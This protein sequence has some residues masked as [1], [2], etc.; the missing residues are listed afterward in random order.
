MIAIER[1]NRYQ[2]FA[3]H[4]LLSLVFFLIVLLLITEFWYPGFLFQSSAGWDAVSLIVGIDLILGPLLT[5]IVFDTNKASLKKDL[6]VILA[7]QLTAL[8]AGSYTIWHT[9]PIAV[10]YHYPEFTTIYA[11]QSVAANIAHLVQQSDSRPAILFYD[12]PSGGFDNNYKKGEFYPYNP[13]SE[14]LVRMI[15]ATATLDT[16]SELWLVPLDSVLNH[17]ARLQLDQQTFRVVG[18]TSTQ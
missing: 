10:V 13:T 6:L 9:R 8:S 15:L 18:V 1:L 17:G 5:L 7:V 4:L 11:N 14:T 2:A 12:D 16:Q 3:I